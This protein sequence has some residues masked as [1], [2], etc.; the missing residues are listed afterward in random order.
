MAPFV[1]AVAGVSYYQDTAYKIQP[2][3]RVWL[4]PEPDNPHDAHAVAVMTDEGARVG[5]M[6]ARLAQR[7]AGLLLGPTPATVWELVGG[8]AKHRGVRVRVALESADA[9][10]EPASDN[11]SPC[12]LSSGRYLGEC[13]EAT[14]EIVVVATP[15]GTTERYPKAVVRWSP[16]EGL[17]AAACCMVKPRHV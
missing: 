1:F 16:P 2:Q 17:Q 10:R 15:T 3:Q 14:E 8:G 11:G 5:Y 9:A 4:I 7:M 6:P 12:W 13:Q